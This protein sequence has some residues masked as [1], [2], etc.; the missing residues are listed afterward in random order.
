MARGILRVWPN[1]EIRSCPLADGGEGTLDALLSGLGAAARRQVRTV[2]GASG[3]PTPVP[4]GV[5]DSPAGPTAILEVAR[6]VGIADPVAMAIPI[7]LRTTRGVGEWL[8]ALLDDGVRHYLIALGGSC[9]NDGGAGMLEALG[10]RYFDSTRATVPPSL[11]TLTTIERVD[12][13][14]LHPNLAEVELTLL[15]DVDNPLSGPRGATATFG[16]QK[17]VP[18]EDV[19]TF[20]AALARF[21]DQVEAALGSHVAESPGAGAAGGLGFALQ[22]LGGTSRSGAEFVADVVGLDAALRGADWLITGE[23]RSDG[24][25]LAGKAPLVAA[26]RARAAGVPATLLSG[27]LSADAVPLLAPHFAGCFALPTSPMTTEASIAGADALLAER[28]EQLARLW[29]AAR[30]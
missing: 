29:A 10:M 3:K 15:S 21:A 5:F 28:T 18:G 24:Q 17:G 13:T 12:A 6:L 25:T 26:R 22:A 1:A 20:D 16:P 14:G 19:A 7:A 4:Y 23:G 27:A 30:A 8:R 9:T 2:S 11:G